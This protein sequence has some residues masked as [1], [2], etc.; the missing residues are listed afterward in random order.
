MLVFSSVQSLKLPRSTCYDAIMILKS[1]VRIFQ[2]PKLLLQT[3]ELYIHI[4][5]RI[6]VHSLMICK[7][8][9]AGYS[10]AGAFFATF[11]TTATTVLVLLTTTVF[12]PGGA[13]T[14]LVTTPPP[15]VIV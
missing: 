14:V 11:V 13:V 6:S 15:R 3:P 7:R 12:V 4:T 10:Q 1:P 5:N 9:P 2:C 8:D